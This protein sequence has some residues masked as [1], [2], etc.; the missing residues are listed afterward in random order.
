M[1]GDGIASVQGLVIFV[2]NGKV[3]QK[4]KTRFT[5]VGPRFATAE[6]VAAPKVSKRFG[7]PRASAKTVKEIF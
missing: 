2:K 4:V 1:F 6:V 5:N 7:I 3:G